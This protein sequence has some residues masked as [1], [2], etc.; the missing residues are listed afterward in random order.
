MKFFLPIIYVCFSWVLYTY[1]I[2]KGD[3]EFPLVVSL[4]ILYILIYHVFINNIRIV[5][6]II[7]N[8]ILSS[9]IIVFSYYF[10]W[11]SWLYYGLQLSGWDVKL[12]DFKCPDEATIEFF[13]L[14]VLPFYIYPILTIWLTDNLNKLKLYDF[15]EERISLRKKNNKTKF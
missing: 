8:C 10:L 15:L 2:L 1:N 14:F 11:Y 4:G 9:A 6:N 12:F 7:K 3:K 13:I 5:F